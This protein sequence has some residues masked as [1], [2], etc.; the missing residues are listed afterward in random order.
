MPAAKRAAP[1]FRIDLIG[2]QRPH[3][4]NA[5]RF[6]SRLAVSLP[7]SSSRPTKPASPIP[8]ARLQRRDFALGCGTLIVLG[9]L[10]G[11]W[12]PSHGASA[13]DDFMLVSQTISGAPLD[14][15]LGLSCFSH[16]HRADD[17]FIEHIQALA[18]LVRRNPGVDA[19]GLARLLDADNARDLRAALVRL[20]DVWSA[21]R[22]ADPALIDVRGLIAC[23]FDADLIDR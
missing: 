8:P 4:E 9:A 3:L 20:V 10:P 14:R 11:F 19:A 13:L 23:A 12:P 15:Q 18:W 5:S 1:A 6:C 7:P 21:R 16:L 2:W 22:D 17:R